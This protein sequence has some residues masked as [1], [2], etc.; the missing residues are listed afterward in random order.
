MSTLSQEAACEP[1]FSFIWSIYAMSRMARRRSVSMPVRF[2]FF[3]ISVVSCHVPDS[4]S[5]RNQFANLVDAVAVTTVAAL[6]PCRVAG[7][8][9]CGQLLD[10]SIPVGKCKHVGL[11]TRDRGEFLLR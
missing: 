11:L 2:N 1:P 5:L 3:T 8:E 9:A 7:L 6:T 4:N 10:L